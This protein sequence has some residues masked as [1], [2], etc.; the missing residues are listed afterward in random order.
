MSLCPKCGKAYCDHEL[1]E[2][3]QTFEEMMRP[4]T[5]D[6]L[7]AWETQDPEKKKA[8]ARRHAHDPVKKDT[9]DSHADPRKKTR[10]IL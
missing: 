6:E 9:V 3:G 4:L 7:K 5:D 8:A 10:I 2:R 1:S